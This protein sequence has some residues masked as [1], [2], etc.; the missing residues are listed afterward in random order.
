[1]TFTLGLP[2]QTVSR[3]RGKE[4]RRRKFAAWPV[5]EAL[6]NEV[7]ISNRGSWWRPRGMTAP[8]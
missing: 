5:A 8:D 6:A 2:V 4:V 1:M 3:A 7:A